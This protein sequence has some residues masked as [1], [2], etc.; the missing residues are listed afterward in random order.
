MQNVFRVDF[1]ADLVLELIVFYIVKSMHTI[2]EKANG[3]TEWDAIQR[4][5]NMI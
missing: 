3:L 4:T 2:G 5:R 1:K